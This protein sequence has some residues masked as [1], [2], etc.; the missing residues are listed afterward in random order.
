MLPL[1]CLVSGNTSIHFQASFSF[2]LCRLCS[3]CFS[4]YLNKNLRK[5]MKC[6]FSQN[7]GGRSEGAGRT[8]G[9]REGV[10]GGWG[11]DGGGVVLVEG[12]RRHKK[13]GT[14]LHQEQ[15]DQELTEPTWKNIN[16]LY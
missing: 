15:R 4:N 9:W 7:K 10:K 16:F 14:N 11:G 3:S 1:N 8:H 6:L 12:T 13:H 5:E 2:I